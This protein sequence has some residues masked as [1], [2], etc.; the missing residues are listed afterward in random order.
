[1]MINSPIFELRGWYNFM[2]IVLLHLQRNLNLLDLQLGN[3]EFI[4]F[5]FVNDQSYG[6]GINH[7]RF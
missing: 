6:Q 3:E 2:Y 5:V 1:M 7:P 4:G